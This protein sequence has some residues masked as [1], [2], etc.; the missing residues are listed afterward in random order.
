MPVFDGTN[1]WVPNLL[2]NSITVVQASTGTVMATIAA[3]ANNLLSDPSAATFDGER[4][5]VTNT[6]G[7]TVSVF[8]AADLSFIANV[9]TGP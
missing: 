8:K 9:T 3:D 4:V 2:G 1:I 7:N 5:L 6:A